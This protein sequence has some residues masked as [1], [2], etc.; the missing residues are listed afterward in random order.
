[1]KLSE[2]PKKGKKNCKKY[3]RINGKT[4]KIKISKKL[5]K[6]TYK[7]KVKVK[8]AGSHNYG[9]SVKKAVFKIKIQ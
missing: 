1:M 7:L 8:A 6:G 2:E 9:P 3:F 5:Q 4:G